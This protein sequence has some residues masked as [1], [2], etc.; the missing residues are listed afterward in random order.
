[1][2]VDRSHLMADNKVF[3]FPVILGDVAEAAA[4]VPDK[5]RERQWSRLN[6]DGSTKAFAERI[7]KLTSG[8]A[9][10]GKSAPNTASN[11]EF[12]DL[13]AIHKAVSP[14]QAGAQ[15][16]PASR[17]PSN[18]DPGLR[19]DNIAGS[20]V[21]IHP[22][23]PAIAVLAIANRSASADDEY[24][25]EGLAD[26]LLNVLARIKG[27]RVAARTSAFLFKDKPSV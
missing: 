22:Q 11:N 8:R 16:Q 26:E 5:F 3:F 19:R 1:M 21:N 15:F 9:S 6:D 12:A 18:L 7:A 10:P 27:L 17:E 14:A 24:F 4:L 25:S 23:V 2:A 20:V 13:A